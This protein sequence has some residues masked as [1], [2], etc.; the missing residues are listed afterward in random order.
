MKKQILWCVAAVALLLSGC[1]K[2]SSPETKLVISSSEDNPLKQVAFVRKDKVLFSLKSEHSVG[3]MKFMDLTSDGSFFRAVFEF[4]G[5]ETDYKPYLLDL[6]GDGDKRYLILTE[7][8]GGN[9]A[10]NYRGYLIDTKDGFSLI[11]EV[12]AGEVQGYPAKNP[13]LLFTYSDSI[14]YFGAQ[15]YA[16]V[17]VDVKLAKGKEP[18]LVSGKWAELSLDSYRSL[19]K[20]QYA[21][22]Y[23]IALLSLYG[24]LASRGE[25]SKAAHYSRLLG[26][27]AKEAWAIYCDSLA[28][29][30]RS[31]LRKQLEQ[32]NG[33]TF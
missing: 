20:E 23:D 18:E 15:G 11:G 26:V 14:A 16:T 8:F 32:L 27:P 13:E 9:D 31:R 12:P 25:L 22:P 24:D 1:G 19:L 3:F 7:W 6:K 2:S 5:S 33:M 4:A 30:K 17:S 28:A 10:F 29:M 21:T